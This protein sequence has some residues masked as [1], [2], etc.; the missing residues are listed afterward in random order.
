VRKEFLLATKA[1]T[2]S[3][4]FFNTAI[5]LSPIDFKAFYNRGKLRLKTKND[6]AL[7][8]LDKATTLSPTSRCSRT[9][10]D[11]FLKQGKKILASLQWRL[12]E[13]LKKKKKK[14]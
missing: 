8:D 14:K 1:N 2:A 3:R 13:E 10:C 4:K 6:G 5:K 11:A 7:A 12:A 9:L